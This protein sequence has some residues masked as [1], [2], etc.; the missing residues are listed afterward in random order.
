MSEAPIIRIE[1]LR[2]VYR[3]GKVDVEALRGV[4]L[5]VQRGEFALQIF[6]TFVREPLRFRLMRDIGQRGNGA[7]LGESVGVEGLARF[8]QHPD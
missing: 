8:L 7:G 2:K 6:A 3:V 5:Q 4:D 1:S